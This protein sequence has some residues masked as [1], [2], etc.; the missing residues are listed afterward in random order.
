M[1]GLKV[2][3]PDQKLT[4]RPA[5]PKAWDWMEIRLPIQSQWTR[6]HYRHDGIQVKGSPIPWELFKQP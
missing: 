2:S 3:L 4:L 6:I 5:L 1:G